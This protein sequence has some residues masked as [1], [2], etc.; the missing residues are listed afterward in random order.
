MAQFILLGQS[1]AINIGA[2]QTM[3]ISAQLRGTTLE[4]ELEV[5][6]DILFTSGGTMGRTLYKTTNKD[7]INKV[8]W[9]YVEATGE[10]WDVKKARK[11]L[12]DFYNIEYTCSMHKTRVRELIRE[13]RYYLNRSDFYT[14]RGQVLKE[15][16]RAKLIED[17]LFKQLGEIW[18]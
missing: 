5:K 13:E 12:K 15:K 2:I 17:D 11:E 1:E 9:D 16:D 7:Y 6:L 3:R 4:P 18:K 10:V 8:S 14:M